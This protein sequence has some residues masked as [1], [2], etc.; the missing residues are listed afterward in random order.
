V[1]NHGGV[2][3]ESVLLVATSA[4]NSEKTRMSK[5][6]FNFVDR[7]RVSS[8]KDAVEPSLHLGPQPGDISGEGKV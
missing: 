3:T 8:S 5:N 6:S 1:L 2:I 4:A 7:C